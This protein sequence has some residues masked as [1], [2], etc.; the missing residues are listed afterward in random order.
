[1][2][3]H[4][5]SGTRPTSLAFIMFKCSLHRLTFVTCAQAMLLN[6]GHMHTFLSDL[7]SGG[8]GLGGGIARRDI[9][10]ARIR[11]G[12]RQQPCVCHL[13]TPIR[14]Q[15]A[16]APLSRLPFEPPN[17]RP[18][19]ALI[20]PIPRASAQMPPSGHCWSNNDRTSQN[21]C[22]AMAKVKSAAVSR[23]ALRQLLTS[24]R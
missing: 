22:L 7:I 23:A 20:V 24:A 16:L 10:P 11:V 6:F 14:S 3:A 19:F 18:Y 4:Y 9:V 5:S 12:S 8:E 1:M 21:V 2:K 13:F 17:P 15:L